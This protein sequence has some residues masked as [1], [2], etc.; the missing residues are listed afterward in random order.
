[1]SKPRVHLRPNQV[2]NLGNT[3]TYCGRTLYSVRSRPAAVTVFGSSSHH[4]DVTVHGALVTC[5]TCLKRMREG[6]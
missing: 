1:M 6:F 4:L 5:E 2:V 3:S